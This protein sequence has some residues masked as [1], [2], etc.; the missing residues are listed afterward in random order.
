MGSL[1]GYS[2]LLPTGFETSLNS[3]PRTFA[4]RPETTERKG[5]MIV[6]NSRKALAK[7]GSW[8]Q[9]LWAWAIFS[10]FE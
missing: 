1:I 8:T 9:S 6:M 5:K 3:N 7:R 4:H 10:E 2:Q